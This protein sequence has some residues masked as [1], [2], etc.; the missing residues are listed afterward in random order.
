MTTYIARLNE[1]KEMLEQATGRFHALLDNLR[2][3]RL[4]DGRER[5]LKKWANEVDAEVGIRDRLIT[6]LDRMGI[7]QDSEEEGKKAEMYGLELAARKGAKKRPVKK[8][9]KKVAAKV[10]PHA[11]TR[12][13]SRKRTRT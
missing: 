1:V 12:L 2:I 9:A 7:F 13:D 11:R 3:L 6:E 4:D 5:L 10:K 8:P